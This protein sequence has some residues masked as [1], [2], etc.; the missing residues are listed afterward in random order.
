MVKLREILAQKLI[1][2]I[3]HLRADFGFYAKYNPKHR[4]YN[5]NLGGGALLDVG[6]Y[7]ISLSSMVL[8]TPINVKSTTIFG[9]TGIDEQNS[10]I[11]EYPK[12]KIAQ[13]SSA[14]RIDTDREAYIAGTKGSIKLDA[15][16][17]RSLKVTVMIRKKNDIIY[18]FDEKS[19]GLKNETLH[20]MN[21]IRFGKRESNIMSLDETLSIMKIMDKIRAQWDLVY[22][23]ET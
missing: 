11:L 4:L 21:C 6:V 23:M 20:M 5:P 3:L 13:L 8:G 19:N 18:N 15:S 17:H 7:P 9:E 10:I 1:G 16:W 12:N 14:I 22:P 2:E